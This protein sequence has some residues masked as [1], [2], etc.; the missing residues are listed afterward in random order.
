[1][2][3]NLMLLL[4][5]DNFPKCVNLLRDLNFCICPKIF[6]YVNHVVA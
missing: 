1:M 3:I 2:G 5:S 4:S 6:M